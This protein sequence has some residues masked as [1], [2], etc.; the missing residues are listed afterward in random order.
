MHNLTEK[1]KEKALELGFDAVGVVPAIFLQSEEKRLWQWLDNGY[2]AEMDYMSRNFEKRLNPALLVDEAKSVIVVIKNYYPEQKQP[3]DTYFVSKY[4]FGKDYHFILKE[5]LRKLWKYVEEING[6]IKGRIFVDSAPVLEKKLAQLAGLG[7]IGKNSLLITKKG[8]YFFIGE[9][10]IN[11]QL[12]YDTPQV[13]DFCGTCT[14]CID[15]CPTNAIIDP[16]IIDAS[17]CISYL[18]IEKKGDFDEKMN[19]N[20]ANY[21]F[22]CDIC[23]DVCPWNSKIIPT[24]DERFTPVEA[25]LKFS[26]K[27]WHEMTKQDFK[28]NFKNTPLERTKYEG[29]KRNIDYVAKQNNDFDVSKSEN[30][31]K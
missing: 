1:I 16:Y 9:M 20:F 26:K 27:D 30:H 8:S 31:K 22:G 13:N 28:S 29:L 12:E 15:A 4:A 25:V 10:I 11:L 19:L 2:N 24:K 5:D 17:K 7:W 23:Q 14:R 3:A 18:T 21:I 6:N